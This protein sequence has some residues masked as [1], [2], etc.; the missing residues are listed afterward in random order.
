MQ[1]TVTEK[2]KGKPGRRA[3]APEAMKLFKKLM[4]DRNAYYNAAAA[5]NFLKFKRM[6]A[7]AFEDF[8]KWYA[9]TGKK[10]VQ[11]FG[12]I[13]T[14]WSKVPADREVFRAYAMETMRDFETHRAAGTIRPWQTGLLERM[15]I[16]ASKRACDAV[17]IAEQF[18]PED[19]AQ[20]YKSLYTLGA[21]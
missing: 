21:L 17:E 18:T 3:R 16:V 11:G 8:H 4:G 6:D 15:E 13:I 1:P 5:E 7:G 14:T 10:G 12:T 20:F 19:R 2:K 9:S